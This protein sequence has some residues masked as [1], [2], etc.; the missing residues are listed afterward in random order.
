[1]A[2]VVPINDLFKKNVRAE[3]EEINEVMEALKE[4]KQYL[5]ELIYGEEI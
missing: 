4:R 5:L 1:M 2:E 3:I